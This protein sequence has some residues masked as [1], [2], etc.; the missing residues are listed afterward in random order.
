MTT[1]K[2]KQ[3]SNKIKPDIRKLKDIE[4][5]VYDK[6]WLKKAFN[7]E[8]YYM[9]RGIEKKDNLRYDITVVPAL[10]LGKEFVKTKGHDH[11]NQYGEIYIV[12]EGKAI[13]LLQKKKNKQLKEDKP[14]SRPFANAQEIED[15]YAVKAKKGDVVI[16]PPFYGHV[17]INPSKKELKMSNWISEKC[18]SDYLPFEEMEGACYFYTKNGWIKNKNYKKVPKLKFKKPIKKIPKD[19]SFLE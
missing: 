7:F 15:V 17:T 9:Y 14:S 19:L 6:K 4:K 13:Y 1:K 10:M 3:V 16:I 2:T 18:Q 12:L 11:L 8:L 5:V